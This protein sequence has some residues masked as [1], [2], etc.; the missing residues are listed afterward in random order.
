LRPGEGIFQDAG[1]PHA[2]LEGACVE[3]MANSDNVLRGGLTPKHIDVPE[4]LDKTDCSAVTA[5]ILTP[6]NRGDGW[7]HYPTPAPDFSLS[8]ATPSKDE[9][10]TID[11]AKGPAILL[12]LEG[13]LQDTA[14][15]LQLDTS[16]RTAFLAAEGKYTF[17]A[18][19]N[20]K[21]FLAEV[22]DAHSS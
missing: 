9:E 12:L 20:T 11:T 21:V 7:Q 13:A 10:L 3:L 17:S 22:G 16:S 8:V 4:L 19:A 6:T 14:T 15:S 1:I 18:S 5:N 2:Y